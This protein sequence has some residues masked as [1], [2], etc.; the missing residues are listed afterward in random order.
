MLRAIIIVG[1]VH[2]QY[3]RWTKVLWHYSGLWSPILKPQDEFLTPS[4]SFETWC[5]HETACLLANGL[6]LLFWQS[7]AWKPLDFFRF[8]NTIYKMNLMFYSVWPEIR[9]WA[10]KLIRPLLTEV[11]AEGFFHSGKFY[12][13]SWCDRSC[14]CVG[15]S[16]IYFFHRCYFN[17]IFFSYSVITK[18]MWDFTR[19]AVSYLN[20]G[21]IFFLFL[22]RG[23]KK[24]FL[25][26]HYIIQVSG[27]DEW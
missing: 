14:D 6:V 20:V 10:H 16:F 27:T 25:H 11:R 26:V 23:P 3:N 9:Y 8:L 21:Y 1:K 4:L 12:P 22:Q 7:C 15:F 5:N 2:I 13:K 19:T 18:W 17:W 24:T